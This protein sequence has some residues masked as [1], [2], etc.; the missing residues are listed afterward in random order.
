MGRFASAMAE[1]TDE[2]LVAIVR[3]HAEDWQPEALEA[4]KEEIERRGL[5]LEDAKPPARA[6]TT[7]GEPLAEAA[8]EPRM[9]IVALLLGV[10]LTGLG[11]VIALGV[12]ASWRGRGERRRAGELVMFAAL[13]FAGSLV[14]FGLLR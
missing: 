7:K 6:R 14:L 13:G 10:F 12:A 3:G 4:A 5:E 8:L 11:L 2:E 9:K 1:R